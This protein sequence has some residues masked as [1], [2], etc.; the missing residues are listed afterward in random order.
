MRHDNE[1]SEKNNVNKRYDNDNEY[2]QIPTDINISENN[3]RLDLSPLKL[4]YNINN[5]NTISKNLSN[6]CI[7]K[8]DLKPDKRDF[9]TNFIKKE[10][11]NNN[12]SKNFLPVLKS[13]CTRNFD[14]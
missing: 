6:K 1:S 14:D 10:K 11:N 4:N 5:V 7:A 12:I 8:Y 2:K 13:S 9:R 3:N